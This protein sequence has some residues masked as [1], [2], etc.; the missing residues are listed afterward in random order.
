[1]K[2]H[3]SIKS[4]IVITLKRVVRIVVLTAVALSPSNISANVKVSDAEGI[5]MTM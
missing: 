1:M 5:A 3:N 4:G 2:L